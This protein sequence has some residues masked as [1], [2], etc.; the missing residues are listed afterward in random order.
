MS[1]ATPLPGRTP[2]GPHRRHPAPAAR[3]RSRG[4]HPPDRGGRRRRRGDH[5]PGVPLESRADR[6]HHR[7]RRL[8]RPPGGPAGRRRRSGL[9][10]PELVL[11]VVGVLQDHARDARLIFAI[12]G[13]G[14]S[15]PPVEGECR[16]PKPSELNARVAGKIAELLAPHA[17][18]LTPD[19]ASA[20]AI[21]L[22]LS[23]GSAFTAPTPD[24][25]LTSAQVAA[26]LLHGIT[27]ENR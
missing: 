19:P 14:R 26:V 22:A 6:R 12:L 18:H 3:P 8:P 15:Q 9:A 5:L 25:G 17:A 2:P 10:L 7:G 20:A 1:R 11:A 24:A 21:V 16:R 13:H 27:K 4:V 23:F